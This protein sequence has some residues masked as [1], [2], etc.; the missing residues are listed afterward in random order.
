MLRDILALIFNVLVVL[1]IVIQFPRDR[2]LL[3]RSKLKNSFETLQTD[4][5]SGFNTAGLRAGRHARVKIKAAYRGAERCTAYEDH[6]ENDQNFGIRPGGV[7]PPSNG[8]A[9][10][11]GGG[12]WRVPWCEAKLTST[13]SLC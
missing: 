1:G 11:D 4:T 6:R 10:C 3:L 5:L 8:P 2:F 7:S 9:C 12:Y 13:A